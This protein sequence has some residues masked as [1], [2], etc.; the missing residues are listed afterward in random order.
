MSR[1]GAYAEDS[2]KFQ[3]VMPLAL[4]E[5]LRTQSST[6]QESVSEIMRKAARQYLTENAPPR[7]RGRR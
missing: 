7:K 4:L 3:L 5:Q 2:T 6:E 1:H